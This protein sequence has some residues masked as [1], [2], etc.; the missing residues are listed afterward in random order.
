[1]SFN[2]GFRG[3]AQG[4]VQD[5]Y[6][7]Q[8]A[9]SVPGMLAYASDIDL[10]DAIFVGETNGVGAG[11][12]IKETV[13]DNSID[14]QTPPVAAYLPTGGESISDFAGVIVFDEGMQCDENGNPGWGLGRVAQR[15]RAKRVGGRI[16]VKVKE[17]VVL[18]SASVNWVVAAGTTN[19]V[20]YVPGDFAPE[21]LGGGAA[22]IS[23]A[24]TTAK[25]RTA[26]AAGGLALLELATA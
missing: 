11:A 20:A 18:G 22:G 4:A 2:T 5:A 13:Y 21:A 9:V 1:M 6:Y 8:P 10:C 16:W 15:L 19:G 12:G 3:T 26:A 14:A 23:V 17:A 24:I 25:W 7:D